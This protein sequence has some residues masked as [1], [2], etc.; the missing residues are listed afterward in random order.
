MK[1][2]NGGIDFLESAAGGFVN[3]TGGIES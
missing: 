3:G 1:S 2:G